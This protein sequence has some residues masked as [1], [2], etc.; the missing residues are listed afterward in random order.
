VELLA[1]RSVAQRLAAYAERG[2]TEPQQTDTLEMLLD[3]IDAPRAL[4]VLV[5]KNGR[6]ESGEKN[7]GSENVMIVCFDLAREIYEQLAPSHP[8]WVQPAQTDGKSMLWLPPGLNGRLR[9]LN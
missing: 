2:M 9:G 4:V 7:L 3:R 5:D 1:A 8:E 6:I